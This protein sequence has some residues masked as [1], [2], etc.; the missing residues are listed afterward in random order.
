M[1]KLTFP[2]LFLI[3][4]VSAVVACTPRAAFA[5]RGGGGARGG[6]GGFHGGGGGFRGMQSAPRYGGGSYRGSSGSPYSRPSYSYRSPY[7]NPAGRTN[8]SGPS[9][10][11]N[12]GRAG[13]AAPQSQLRGF[14][15]A[16]G[17][18]HSF[19]ER[20]AGAGTGRGL[21]AVS[22]RA[23]IPPTLL[24]RA[25][26]VQE[27]GRDKVMQCGQ[28][29]LGPPREMQCLGLKRFRTSRARWA[30]QA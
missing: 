24:S 28:M 30:A 12:A 4:I 17:Q 20:P 25:V 22:T 2:K 19:G 7:G 14:A 8:P 23:A 27:V 5:Q 29:R 13:S 15:N 3:A 6:G 11:V 9:R 16:D 18:W 1:A 10:G 26:Q 21:Q